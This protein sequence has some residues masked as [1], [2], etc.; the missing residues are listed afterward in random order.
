[1]ESAH[2]NIQVVE[3]EKL[4]LR[5]KAEMM[6]GAW[7]KLLQRSEDPSASTPEEEGVEGEEPLRAPLLEL[8]EEISAP[9]P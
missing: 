9:K 2:V 6:Q 4:D 3:L 7:S 8:K 5:R 1:M